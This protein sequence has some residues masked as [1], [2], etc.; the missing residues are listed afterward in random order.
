ME[1]L[2]FYIFSESD[3]AISATAPSLDA[4]FAL[5]TI[6]HFKCEQFGRLH[7]VLLSQ[8]TVRTTPAAKIPRCCV[9]AQAAPEMISLC[10]NEP[11]KL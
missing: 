5:I 2:S 8:M 4:V 1:L 6:T 9:A 3:L 7:T 11:C 10:Q